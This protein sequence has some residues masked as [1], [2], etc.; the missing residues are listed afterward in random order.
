MRKFLTFA[1]I[2]LGTLACS[3]G[4][5][6]EIF[7][8]EGQLI[9]PDEAH[10]NLSDLTLTNFSTPEKQSLLQR[11]FAGNGRWEVRQERGINYAVRL[12]KVNGNYQTSLNGY[13]SEYKE[14]GSVSQTRV[15]VSFKEPYGFG[16]LDKRITRSN[17]GNNDAE[18][19]IADSFPGTPGYASYLI[20]NG[21][22]IYIEIYD[23]APQVERIFT[24]KAYNEISKELSAILEHQDEIE[25]TGIMLLEEY[26]PGAFPKASFL[27]VKDGMQPG[28]YLVDAA[29]NPTGPGILFVKV[30]DTK[31]GEQLSA[32]RITPRS[33][34]VAA[35][36]DAGVTYF[37]YQ[38]EITISEG[39]WN[40]KYEAR[41]ELWHK[42]DSGTET[43]LLETTRLV[44]GWQR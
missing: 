19:I 16:N 38:S 7:E 40:T 12:E 25:T 20:V 8:P 28:I 1:I 33:T 3:L 14:N 27:D 24:Q 13:Y 43:K 42:D 22:G 9:H 10:V 26:Y 21:G 6:V 5:P 30:F 36:S 35:W 37:P 44:N 41:F 39:D 2:L 32:D 29:V 23:Q 17:T 15:L 11:Y 4:S 31:T 34:R 18:L